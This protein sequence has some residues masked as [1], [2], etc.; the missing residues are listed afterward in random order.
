MAGSFWEVSL[1]VETPAI[2][3]AAMPIIAFIIYAL[4]PLDNLDDP[5]E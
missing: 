2:I 3:I 4:V 1:V 5:N